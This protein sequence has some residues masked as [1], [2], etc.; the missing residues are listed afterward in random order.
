IVSRGGNLLLNIGPAADGTIPVIMQQRLMDIGNWLRING[1][2]IYG[3]RAWKKAPPKNDSGIYFTQ[4]GKDLYLIA[5]SWNDEWT[6]SG[7]NNPSQVKLLGFEGKTD[8]RFSKGKL[9]I[10]APRV[11]PANNPSEHAWVFRL[12]NA[13]N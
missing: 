12:T 1:E 11:T 6:I 9:V 2:A 13:T 5:T 4:K 8:A 3:T 7:I 10:R